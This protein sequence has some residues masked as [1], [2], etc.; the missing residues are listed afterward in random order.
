M[1]AAHTITRVAEALNWDL[2]NPESFLK[3]VQHVEFGLS[4][5]IEL[6]SILRWLGTCCFVHRLS[7]DILEEP[8]RSIW[9][10]PDLFAIFEL[11]GQVVSAL[12][13]VKTNDDFELRFRSGYLERLQA[14]AAILKQPLLIA[15]K[16]RR[17]G[18]WLL[19]D[20]SEIPASGDGS[21]VVDL[22]IAFQNDLMSILAGDFAIVPK[23]GAGLRVEMVRVGEKV[24][25][26]DGYEAKFV[27]DQAFLRDSSGAEIKDAPETIF[28]TILSSARQHEEI[29]DDRVVQEWLATGGLTRAQLVLRT[30]AGFPLNE[31]ERIHWKSIGRNLNEIITR[32]QILSDAKSQFG[33]SISYV[34]HQEPKKRPSFLPPD[35]RHRS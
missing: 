31:A 24:P 28:W 5:E 18:L 10:V 4:A 30:V 22:N 7:E 34:F 9:Q 11:D 29:T 2:S 25:A 6:A 15:W 23:E 19:F 35:W 1:D 27:V 8:A 13:E 3:H 20:S 17:L 33:S 16:P 21:V 14:Y 12:I 32:E 26:N